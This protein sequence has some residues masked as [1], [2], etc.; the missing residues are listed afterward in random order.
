MNRYN[1]IT[2][3]KATLKKATIILKEKL[4]LFKSAPIKFIKTIGSYILTYI[5]LFSTVGK[6]AKILK[7]FKYCYWLFLLISG[8]SYFVFGYQVT[9]I[10]TVVQIYCF[11]ILGR[12]D[13]ILKNITEFLKDILSNYKPVEKPDWSKLNEKIQDFKKAQNILN[14]NA[15]KPSES[16]KSIWNYDK[17]RDDYIRAHNPVKKSWYGFTYDFLTSHKYEI[18]TGIVIISGVTFIAYHQGDPVQMGKAI[19]GAS[20]AIGSWISGK[21]NDIYNWMKGTPKSD[22]TVFDAEQFDVGSLGKT[23]DPLDMSICQS[24]I[25]SVKDRLGRELTQAQVDAVV[26]KHRN[27]FTMGSL[28]TFESDCVDDFVRDFKAE[29]LVNSMAKQP[30]SPEIAAWGT[31]LPNVD[32]VSNSAEGL[33][34]TLGGDSTPKGSTIPSVNTT[35]K[36]SVKSL[37]SINPAPISFTGWIKSLFEKDV[38]S[39][40]PINISD[41]RVL[42]LVDISNLKPEDLLHDNN[43]ALLEKVIH[44]YFLPEVDRF[45]KTLK[46]SNSFVTAAHGEKLTDLWESHLK[47]GKHPES[48]CLTVDK[49]IGD[50]T[51]DSGFSYL[52]NYFRTQKPAPETDVWANAPRSVYPEI[53]ESSPLSPLPDLGIHLPE[54]PGIPK[55][56]NS[57]LSTNKPLESRSW[58]SNFKVGLFGNSDVSSNDKVTSS[59]SPKF[60][61]SYELSPKHTIL[62]TDSQETIT[63]FNY[64][65]HNLDS[66]T[67]KLNTIYQG[68]DFYSFTGTYQANYIYSDDNLKEFFKKYAK[69]IVEKHLRN[70]V[71]YK[72]CF[73]IGGFFIDENPL[74]FE[75]RDEDINKLVRTENYIVKFQNVSSEDDLSFLLRMITRVLLIEKD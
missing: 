19:T 5:S 73:D 67:S 45:E 2:L 61:G 22:T 20:T 30:T 16:K 10:L 15:I 42:P 6:V 59:D 64:V 58:L 28:G 54:S 18:L 65:P 33:G 43:R 55:N 17:L 51:K 57:G 39:K 29:N 44:D 8:I 26:N 40:N 11:A 60:P 52:V 23:P 4:L 68:M 35:P 38:E 1:L 56:S 24:V 37:D 66:L 9:E 27:Y 49:M 13:I 25:D 31:G 69:F 63:P 36:G 3:V 47:S 46:D 72:D 41:E 74:D 50:A 75:I 7:F 53:K 21:T 62:R 48:F 32:G 34:V 71:S 14:E 70:N 12:L